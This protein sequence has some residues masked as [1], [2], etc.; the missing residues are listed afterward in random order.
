MS[1]NGPLAETGS[2]DGDN[3][4]VLATTALDHMERALDLLDQLDG[5]DGAD[6]HLDM[7]IHRL[8]DWISKSTDD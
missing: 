6:A 3:P 1:N 8:R 5:A 2:A 7:A 4:P